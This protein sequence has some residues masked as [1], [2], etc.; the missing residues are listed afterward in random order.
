MKL[1]RPAC[2][3]GHFINT[4]LQRGD[5]R[6]HDAVT[7]SA[8]FIPH[9]KTAEPVYTR[10]VMLNHVSVAVMS[11]GVETSRDETVKLTLRDSSTSLGMTIE[12]E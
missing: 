1:Q 2:H 3:D 10:M 11:S 7:A 6:F 5:R 8:V 12:H 9:R 4:A